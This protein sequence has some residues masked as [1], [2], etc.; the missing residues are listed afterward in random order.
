MPLGSTVVG[1]VV[2]GAGDTTSITSVILAPETFDPEGFRVTA[3]A[4]PKTTT[5]AGRWSI[6]DVPPGTY[7]VLAGYEKDGFVLDPATT[8]PKIVVTGAPGEI[9]TVPEP[10][11]LVRALSIVIIDPTS[12]APAITVV[13]HPGEDEYAVSV[14]DWKGAVVHSKTEPA[15]SGVTDVTFRVDA[16]LV[17]PLQYR[18]RVTA[19]KAGVVSTLT[20]DVAGVFRATPDDT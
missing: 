18:F 9:V 11:R 7:L 3:P 8:P 5:P 4:G 19:K 20:E 10:Q 15:A 12:T 2:V 14:T 1:E 17:V 6:T 16:D 13:D